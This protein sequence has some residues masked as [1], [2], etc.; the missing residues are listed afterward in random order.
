VRFLSIALPPALLALGCVGAWLWPELAATCFAKEGLLD[1][2]GHVVLVLAAVGWVL[3]ARRH[4]SWSWA[5][6]LGCVVFLG[7][8]IDWGGVYLGA[9]GNLHNALGGASHLLFGIP[10]LAYLAT[11]RS[12]QPAS[13]TMGEAVSITL[14]VASSIVLGLAL[15]GPWERWTEELQELA[16]YAWLAFVGWR[17]RQ[18]P[19]T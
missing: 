18:D 13:P 11:S 14:T 9:G 6:P 4:G 7:E 17:V 10:I 15:G 19:E 1:R 8:E 3:A 2:A 16:L 5:L 12:R